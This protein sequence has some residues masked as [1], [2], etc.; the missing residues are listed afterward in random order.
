MHCRDDRS[1]SHTATTRRRK[2]TSGSNFAAVLCDNG[3]V[4]VLGRNSHGQLG[5]LYG[6]PSRRRHGGEYDIDTDVDTDDDWVA[7][8]LPLRG[9]AVDIA[10]GGLHLE[11]VLANGFLSSLG[12]GAQ[13]QLGTVRIRWGATAR[14]V[15]T[16]ID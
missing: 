10:A 8:R 15:H 1:I 13:G 7:Q 9:R 16:L 14:R 12:W 6:Q 5:S 4:W 11:I 2:L 3:D